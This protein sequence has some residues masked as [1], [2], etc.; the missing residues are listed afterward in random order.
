M[1]IYHVQQTWRAK[2]PKTAVNQYL[3]NPPKSPEYE[4]SKG[5]GKGNAVLKPCVLYDYK[6]KKK[7]S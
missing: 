3:E 2:R 1:P 4:F 6:E 7:R 5:C